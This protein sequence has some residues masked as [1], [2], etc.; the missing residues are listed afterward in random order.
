MDQSVYNKLPKLEKSP[1][2]ATLSDPLSAKT[3]TFLVPPESLEFDYRQERSVLNVLSTNA[4][5]S[6]WKYS[7]GRLSLPDVKLWTPANDRDLTEP[8]ET[9][10][11]WTQDD[12]PVLAF[13]WGSLGLDA[14]YLESFN[15]KV[16]QI[17]T[18]KPTKAQGSMVLIPAPP[19]REP[20]R[21]LANLEG[22]EVRMSEREAEKYSALLDEVFPEAERRVLKPDGTVILDGVELPES[23]FDIEKSSNEALT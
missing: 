14:C 19:I 5:V 16:T 21:D 10:V 20:L 17:R 6:R 13:Q 23:I 11:S 3:Y 1:T 9:L 18:G 2:K 4:G 7:Q 15:F 8:L 12:P 22:S